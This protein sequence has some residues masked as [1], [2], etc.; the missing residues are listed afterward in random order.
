MKFITKNYL[1]KVLNR[2]NIMDNE[3][4]RSMNT[5][6]KSLVAMNVAMYI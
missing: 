5:Y 1:K 2:I 4:K 3:G 6:Y